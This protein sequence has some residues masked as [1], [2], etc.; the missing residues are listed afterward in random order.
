MELDRALG[1]DLLVAALGKTCARCWNSFGTTGARRGDSRALCAQSLARRR[2][3]ALLDAP[4]RG[5]PARVAETPIGATGARRGD[6]CSPR[7]E[8]PMQSAV[9]EG[10]SALEIRS[11]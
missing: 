2:P 6:S 7:S 4:R 9:F 5:R 3:L 1:R 10:L 8:M 11:Q